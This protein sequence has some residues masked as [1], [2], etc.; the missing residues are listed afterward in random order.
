MTHT[1]TPPTDPTTSLPTTN[2]HPMITRSKNSIHKPNPKYG[3]V[4]TSFIDD[5]VPTSVSQALR[6]S[7]WRSAMSAEFDASST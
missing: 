3:L 2:S 5:H 4:S 1:D 7:R 6:D